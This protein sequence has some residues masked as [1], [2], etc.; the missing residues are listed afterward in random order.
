MEYAA[1]YR[2]AQILAVSMLLATFP[3][4]TQAQ[5][6]ERTVEQATF[7]RTVPVDSYGG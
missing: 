1:F 5:G 2:T 3:F 4:L 7:Y 6:K